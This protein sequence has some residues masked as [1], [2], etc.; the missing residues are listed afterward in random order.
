M[1]FN[2]PLRVRNLIRRHGTASPR[3]IA[4]DLGFTVWEWEEAPAKINGL[5]RRILRRK[6]I[7]VDAS[8]AP[9]QKDAV[10]AHELGH[11][12]LHRGY[13]NFSLEGRTYFASARKEQEANEFAALLMEEFSPMSQTAVVDFLDHSWQKK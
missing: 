3:S 5:W 10:I 11:F 1:T 9:W 6:Y 7:V 2:I 12:F 13:K 4:E 8:L